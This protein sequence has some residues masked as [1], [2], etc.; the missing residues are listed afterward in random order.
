MFRPS[1]PIGSGSRFF[2]LFVFF[3]AVIFFPLRGA[4]SA[5]TES[6]ALKAVEATKGIP[7]IFA[8]KQ[9]STCGGEVPSQTSFLGP[10]EESYRLFGTY[11]SLRGNLTA[12]LMLNN[13]GPEPIFATPTFYSLAGTK[14]TLAPISVPAASYSDVD[15]RQLLAHADEEFR[16]GSLK[17][18]Y[19]GGSLQL[20]A[21]VKLVDEQ[22]NLILAEQL[23]YASKFTSNKLENVWRLPPGQSETTLAISNTTYSPLTVAITVDGTAPQQDSPAVIQLDPSQ[24]RIL[25]I[26]RD[27]AGHEN[28][29]LQSRGG[30]SISHGGNPGALLAKMMVAQPNRGYSATMGFIDPESTASQRWHGNGLRLRHLD[31][32]LLKAGLVARNTT[33]QVSRIWGRI[34]YTMPNGEVSHVNIPFTRINPHSTKLIDL[35]SLLDGASVPDSVSYAGI[36]LEYDTPKGSVVTSVMSVSNDGDHVFQVPMFDPQKLPS[37]AG[38]FPWKADGDHTTIVYIK[39]ETDSPKKYTASL[40]FEGGGYSVGVRDLKPSQTAA[41]DFKQ[42]RDDQVP[43][44][45]GR[46]LPFSLERGQIAWSMFGMDNKTLSGRSE[47]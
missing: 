17:I 40:I 25:D 24:T 33:D 39:N 20:G 5:E 7:R 16:E 19:E 38:G 14:L 46:T 15:L 30:I 36:E 47:Q 27:I 23:I 22:R 21:Q 9:I 13:K 11:Y 8:K 35:Q 42:L 3:L 12:A 28:G 18:N 29:T 37:S 44:S 32:S 34:P 41:V 2:L 6:V 31:G 10:V 1:F 4:E 26:M 43:D 45:M